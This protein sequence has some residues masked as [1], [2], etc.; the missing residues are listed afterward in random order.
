MTPATTPAIHQHLQIAIERDASDLHIVPGYFPTIR[1]NEALYAIRTESPISKKDAEGLLLP[2]L[3]DAQL[4]IYREHLQYDF[5][6]E[7]NGHRFRANFYTVKGAPAATFR[8]ISPAIRTISELMLPPIFYE[9]TKMRSGL[10]LITGPTGEGKS[11]TLAAV[12]NE[13]NMNY[14]K[15]IITIE[16]PIEYVYPVA[17]SIVSQRELN[18]DTYS[19]ADALKGALREDPDIVLIGEMRDLETTQAALT[20]AETGHLVL[21]TLHTSSTPEAIN[22]ILDIFPSHQ[23]GM[24]RS[25]LSSTLRAVVAQRLVPSLTQGRIPAVEVLVNTAGVSN[26]IRE[27]KIHLIDNMIETGEEQGMLLFEKYLTRLYQQGTIS[28]ETAYTYALRQ[29][30]ITKFIK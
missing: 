18:S 7:M 17:K 10:I 1:V 15:H 25:Q 20:I 12:I 24:I 27:S 21:S 16:D 2:I 13:I 5:S 6:Y 28:K 19:F 22:R 9:F 26:A 11:T 14:A 4:K 8:I 3:S 29:S 30:E 23:Q